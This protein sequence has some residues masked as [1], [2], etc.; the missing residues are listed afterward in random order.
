MYEVRIRIRIFSKEQALL[1]AAKR[2]QPQKGFSYTVEQADRVSPEALP[3]CDIAVLELP[4]AMGAGQLR[5]GCRRGAKLV[6]YGRPEE[7]AALPQETLR[8]ADALWPKPLTEELAAFY[9]D[10][11][12][13]GI[14]REKDLWLAENYLDSAINSIPDLVWFKDRKGAHLK[15][16]D[17]FCD[18][19][20]KT[21]EAIEGRGHY[22]IWDVEKEEYDKGEYVCLDTDETVLREKKTCLFDE[23]VKSRH[24][25]RQFKTY[26]SPIFDTDGRVIGTV[27]VAHDVTD[28]ENMDTE[29][30]ILLRSM[31][32]S[33]LVENSEGTILKVNP[34][35]EQYFRVRTEELTGRSFAEWE[36]KT[37]RE[38]TKTGEAGY[39]EA[40]LYKDG[41]EKILEVR[42]NPIYDIFLNLAGRLIIY[43]D[44]TKV[45]RMEEEIL[46][47]SNTDFLT[48]LSN[49]RYFYEYVSSRRGGSMVSLIYLDLDHFKQVNDTFGH[50]AGDEALVLTAQLLRDSFPE[51]FITR[52]GG[53]EFLITVLGDSRLEELE[54]RVTGLLGRMQKTFG[55]SRQFHILTA[56]VG[57]ARTRDRSM[58]LDELLRQSD[59]AL[60]QAK[61]SGRNRCCIYYP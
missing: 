23:K 9:F 39:A 1:T 40:Y 61:Q 57:I 38:S 52:L 47:N 58:S 20:G 49:R 37:F 32:Y 24:G 11:L 54:E 28:L 43:R 45:R 34:R 36:K 8:E 3:D 44:V 48:G 46:H 53:D 13:L 6:Y 60:Y 51:D 42:E 16:N 30:G 31:P 29:M 15:V 14:K 10:R 41:E 19:V 59:R 35:F 33:I 25:L 21:R 5:A 56:S 50:Q 22:D 27:G 7:F 2:M 55:A 17:A 12:L 18:A 26:K 4:A